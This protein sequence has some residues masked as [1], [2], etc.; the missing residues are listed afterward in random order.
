MEREEGRS[1]VEST[2]LSS[3]DPVSRPNFSLLYHLSRAFSSTNHQLRNR[4]VVVLA[5]ASHPRSVTASASSDSDC[6]SGDHTCNAPSEDPDH[7][8]WK[9][10]AWKHSAEIGAA[11][12]PDSEEE[13][14]L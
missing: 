5:I 2:P 11:G 13:T 10:A 8:L 9:H 3:T 14:T 4:N 1:W 7:T 6:D 12:G